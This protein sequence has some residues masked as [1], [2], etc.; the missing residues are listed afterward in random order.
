MLEEILLAISETNQMKVEQIVRQALSDF[1]SQFEKKTSQ[2]PQP[3]D[4]IKLIVA[5]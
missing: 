3:T 4:G 2:S 1:L 5:S